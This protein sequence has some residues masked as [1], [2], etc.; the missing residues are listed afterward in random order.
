MYVVKFRLW[1]FPIV[2]Y[3]PKLSGL[4]TPRS[5]KCRPQALQTGSPLLFLLHKV[6]VFELQFAHEKPF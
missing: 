1:K 5:L 6:V 2:S 4:L 3:K